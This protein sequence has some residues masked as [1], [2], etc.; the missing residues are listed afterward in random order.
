MSL[1]ATLLSA[2]NTAA[3]VTDDL[4]LDATYTQAGTVTYSASTGTVTPNSTALPV[5]VQFGKYDAGEKLG[6]LREGECRLFM[7]R[8]ALGSLV[9]SESDRVTQGAAVWEVVAVAD[10]PAQSHW[11]LVVRRLQS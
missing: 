4:W 3:T 1:K 6:V 11:A 9:P 8:A 2:F 7:R 10:N 5:R